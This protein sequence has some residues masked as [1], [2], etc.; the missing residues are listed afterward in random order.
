MRKKFVFIQ[1]KPW[2]LANVKVAQALTKQFPDYDMDIVNIESL[3]KAN[4]FILA[5]NTLLVC[6]TYGSDILTGRKKFKEAFW[7]TSYIFITVKRLLK[8]EL[9]NQGYIF[10]FQM[11]SLIHISEPTRPY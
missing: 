1:P 9:S 5:V 7:H 8:K 3:V 11:L 4:I 10:T 2:P 6:L